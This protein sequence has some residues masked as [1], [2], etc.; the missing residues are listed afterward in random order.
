MR[1]TRA[2]ERGPGAAHGAQ[3]RLTVQETYPTRIQEYPGVSRRFPEY[4][5]PYLLVNDTPRKPIRH[6]AYRIRIG[7]VS[8]P[9]P[10]PIRVRYG[11]GEF[12]GVSE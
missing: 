7:G 8:Y 11:Y 5:R 1:L 10:Y 4:R 6:L 2:Q 12:F 3:A 9:Y